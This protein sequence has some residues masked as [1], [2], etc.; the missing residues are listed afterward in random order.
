V[1]GIPIY[2]SAVRPEWIDYN[3]HVRDAYY[4][5][6]ASEAT[7]ALMDR[8]GLD[9]AYRTRTAA[10]LYTVEMHVHFLEEVK[11]TDTVEVGVHI[12]GFDEKRI[13]AAFDIARSGTPK[14]AAMVEMMLL[15][16]RQEPGRAAT[17]PFPPAIAS[18]LA[19]LHAASAARPAAGPG[20]RRMELRAR[21]ASP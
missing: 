16:V 6:I 3:G 5:L 18:R 11:Q 21:P 10:T 19:Q 7:D 15:H 4:G 1:A 13:H 14:A 8:L 17:A 9:A 2:R 20:S 12:L